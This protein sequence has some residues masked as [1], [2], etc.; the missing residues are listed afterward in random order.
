M[1]IDWSSLFVRTRFTRFFFHTYCNFFLYDL[2]WSRNYSSRFSRRV[3]EP[4]EVPRCITVAAWTT[5]TSS[6]A[7][8]CNATRNSPLMNTIFS[9]LR[10]PSNFSPL[11]FLTAVFAVRDPVLHDQSTCGPS[12]FRRFSLWIAAPHVGIMWIEDIVD[13]GYVPA[14]LTLSDDFL[15]RMI[16][17]P[18]FRRFVTH[19]W[20]RL[21]TRIVGLGSMESSFFNCKD[22]C[23]YY[24]WVRLL[25]N[26]VQTSPSMDLKMR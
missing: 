1:I 19:F 17:I 15:V 2:Y 18:M 24:V 20:S 9:L 14:S 25:S 26:I 5:H 4:Y 3:L 12:I 16:S 21:P 6:I 8:R 23:R 10:V 22:T 13:V 7:N 11:S